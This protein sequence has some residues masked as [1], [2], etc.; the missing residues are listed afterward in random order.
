MS[1]MGTGGG[2]FGQEQTICLPAFEGRMR[3]LLRFY[4][5]FRETEVILTPNHLKVTREKP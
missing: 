3:W 5:S 4:N 2:D 1:A